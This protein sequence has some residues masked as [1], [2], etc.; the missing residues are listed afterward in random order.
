MFRFGQNWPPNLKPTG[1]IENSAEFSQSTHISCSIISKKKNNKFSFY[2]LLIIIF[3][4]ELKK[5]K[6]GG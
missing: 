4:N 6:T 3:A 1:P 2:L 5:E